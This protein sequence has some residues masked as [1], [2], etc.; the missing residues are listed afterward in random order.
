MDGD[1][2]LDLKVTVSRPTAKARTVT[3]QSTTAS[4]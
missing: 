4:A 3:D 2:A 1:E